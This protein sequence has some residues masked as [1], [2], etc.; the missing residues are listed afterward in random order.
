[1]LA[2]MMDFPLDGASG[3]CWSYCRTYPTIGL[4]TIAELGSH[5]RAVSVVDA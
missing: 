1:M 2:R 5:E 3:V 4:D